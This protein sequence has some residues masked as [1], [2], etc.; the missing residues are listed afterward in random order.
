MSLMC[1]VLNPFSGTIWWKPQD[2]RKP[3]FPFTRCDGTIRPL[4]S[5]INQ[6][7]SPVDSQQLFQ[8]RRAQAQIFK[9]QQSYPCLIMKIG[10]L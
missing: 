3:R 9:K 8:V 1:I 6:S 7:I 5:G 2:L 4:G 10:I